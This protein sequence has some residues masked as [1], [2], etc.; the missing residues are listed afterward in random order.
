MRRH[1]RF[2]SLQ[3][4]INQKSVRLHVLVVPIVGALVRTKSAQELGIDTRHFQQ[5]PVR[6]GRVPIH[7]PQQHLL[8]CVGPHA[9]V[10]IEHIRVR[11]EGERQTLNLENIA[12]HPAFFASFTNAGSWSSV[13]TLSVAS[14][15][16]RLSPPS[17]E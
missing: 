11:P 6:P 7:A 17:I 13:S 12:T 15:P 14:A 1:K 9:E 2:N 3:T 16:M 5:S 8:I 10:G 4:R